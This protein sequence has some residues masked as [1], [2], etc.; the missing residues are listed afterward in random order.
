MKIGIIPNT[1]KDDIEAIVILLIGKLRNNG[2]VSVLEKDF[3][4]RINKEKKSIGIIKAVNYE[5]LAMEC[6]IIASVGGDGTMLATSYI[7]RKFDKPVMGINFG[8]LG[9]LAEL[10]I[11]RIDE[12]LKEIKEGKYYIEDRLVILAKNLVSEE[13]ELAAINDIVIDKGGNLKMIEILVKVDG[14]YVA[15]FAA[16]GIILATP[17]GSTGYSISVGGPVVSPKNDVITLSPISP[18][19]LTI[20]SLVLPSSSN[21]YIKAESHFPDLQISCDG[22]R[23]YKCKN[24]AEYIITKSDK[25]LKLLQPKSVNYFKILREKLFWGIDA[26][27]K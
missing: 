18:H 6:D 20:R 8:K 24:P 15:S 27:K 2:F 21:I 25:P 17:I 26:R 10:D 12:Y 7:A 19:S 11:D 3:E 13:N 5:A 16:D 4:Q 23:I 22:Q 14:D 1:V 9:F